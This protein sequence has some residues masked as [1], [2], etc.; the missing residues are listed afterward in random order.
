MLDVSTAGWAVTFA[1]IGGLLAGDIAL[2]AGGPT[3]SASARRCLVGLLRR[4]PRSPRRR[5]RSYRGLGVRRAVLRRLRRREEPVRRQPLRVRRD[6]VGRSRCRA[7]HQQRVLTFGIAAA[8]VLRAV[9]HRGRRRAPVAFASCCSSSGCCSSSPPIQLFRH[10]DQDP[11]RGQRARPRGPTGHPV[12]RPLCRRPPGH[13]RSRR[14]RVLTPLVFRPDR[15]RQHPPLFAL[16]LIPAVFGVTGEA[17]IAS[18]R[19]RSRSSDCG[20]STFSSPPS[21]I[22][23]STSPLASRCSSS[24]A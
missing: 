5:V 7:E 20:L 10:R 14:R 6:H 18:P 3:S 21:S 13:P 17:Y 12:H 2:S 4:P 8:L 22:G 19:T 9:V 23:S 11:R 1:L 24:S 15:D 16:D